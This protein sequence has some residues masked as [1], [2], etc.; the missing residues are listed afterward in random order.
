MV[1]MIRVQEQRLVVELSVVVLAEEGN[2]DRG[3]GLGLEKLQPFLER[4]VDV[5]L[6]VCADDDGAAS[7]VCT[8]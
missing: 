1:V 3:Q 4:V 6:A 5:N 8:S 7:P 2:S